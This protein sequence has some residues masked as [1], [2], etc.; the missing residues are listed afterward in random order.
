MDSQWIRKS[1][2]FIRMGKNQIFIGYDE[3]GWFGSSAL[4]HKM[5]TRI[6]AKFHFFL[7]SSADISTK[8][9]DDIKYILQ[10]FRKKTLVIIHVPHEL[11]H[12]IWEF[13]QVSDIKD[14]RIKIFAERTFPVF[15]H[16]TGGTLYIVYR[17]ETIRAMCDLC[18]E[19]TDSVELDSP[20]QNSEQRANLD[21]HKEEIIGRFKSITP[22]GTLK[23]FKDEDDIWDYIKMENDW[24]PERKKVNINAKDLGLN[25]N[26]TQKDY[27]NALRSAL[28][29]LFGIDKS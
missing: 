11:R 9:V 21:E 27:E 13:D 4:I 25:Q 6:D 22:L 5:N 3:R 29:Q 17:G 10:N 23:S 12:L 19:I 28:N 14:D 18:Y 26:A 1:G 15:V 2:N 16:P 24:A 20:I 8:L 7:G